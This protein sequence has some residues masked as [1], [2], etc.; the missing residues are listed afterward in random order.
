MATKFRNIELVFTPS[1]DE[2][3]ELRNIII[4]KGLPDMID[5]TLSGYCMD[6]NEKNTMLLR[7]VSNLSDIHVLEFSF[8]DIISDPKLASAEREIASVLEA[9]SKSTSLSV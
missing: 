4:E 6:E 9:F 2:A 3:H 7:F 8:P 1:E 5:E